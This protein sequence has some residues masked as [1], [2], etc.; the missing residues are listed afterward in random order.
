MILFYFVEPD[1]SLW[2]F[3]AESFPSS[4]A[5]FVAA[6]PIGIALVYA[7]WRI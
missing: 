6:G 7:P 1:P 4:G 2:I 5:I 3:D